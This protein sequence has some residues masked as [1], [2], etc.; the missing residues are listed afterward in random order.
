MNGVF[1]SILLSVAAGGDGEPVSFKF[2]TEAA[3]RSAA[4]KILAADGVES[5]GCKVQGE[6][7][8]PSKRKG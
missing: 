1:L 4:L 5:V 6:V 7:K 8:A 2:K 3:C